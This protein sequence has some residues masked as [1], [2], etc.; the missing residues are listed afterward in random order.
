MK[1]TKPL[2]KAVVDLGLRDVGVKNDP[3]GLGMLFGKMGVAAVLL[4]LLLVFV[5][6]VAL[7]RLGA[8][9]VATAVMGLTVW[10]GWQL[11][12]RSPVVVWRVDASGT[13]HAAW[14]PVVLLVL[15]LPILALDRSPTAIALVA[16]SGLMAILCL[17]GRGRVPAAVRRLGAGLAPDENIEGDGIG[18][19][20]LLGRDTLRLIVCTDRRVLIAGGDATM[21]DAPYTEL[22]GFGI[23][24]SPLGRVGTLTLDVGAE[25]HRIGQIAPLNL[26]SIARALRGHGVPPQDPAVLTEA[27]GIWARARRSPRSPVPP[28][29]LWAF[30]SRDFLRG[31]GLLLACSAVL[32]YLR[33]LGMGAGVLPLFAL[34]CLACGYLCGTRASLAYLPALA[35]LALPGFFFMDTVLLVVLTTMFVAIA[36]VCLVAGAT[37]RMAGNG[38]VGSVRPI[39]VAA[40]L[41]LVTISGFLGLD[42]TKIRLAMAQAAAEELRADGRSNLAGGYATVR[43]TP[44]AGL[45][46]FVVDEGFDAGPDDGA[47]WEVRT[48]FS[49]GDNSVSVT[50]YIFDAPPLTDP[51]AIAEFVAGKDAEHAAL[52]GAPV[53]HTERT[54]DGR[55]GYVWEHGGRRGHWTYAAWFPHPVH[56]IRVECIA[57]QKR[58]FERLCAEAMRSLEFG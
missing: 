51:A 14:I 17:K 43:Y 53:R 41:A 40:V 6:C 33:P 18:L 42:P 3:R 22:S 58:R 47:R 15:T 50:H 24:W 29:D 37:L 54:V 7:G 34:V 57:L 31:L 38:G 10:V 9:G 16:T 48:P 35:L 44:S 26:L 13:N 2:Y 52:A 21:V 30:V 32:F 45:R 23:R 19:A 5:V 1:R 56:T 39:G 25:T 46:E 11:V 28:L 4:T 20:K 8:A 27:E 49:K 36:G 12:K 55:T